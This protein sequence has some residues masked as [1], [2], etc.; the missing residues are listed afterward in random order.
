MIREAVSALRERF[1]G[2]GIEFNRCVKTFYGVGYRYGPA[3]DK[4]G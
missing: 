3:D 4:Q 2:L 1:S